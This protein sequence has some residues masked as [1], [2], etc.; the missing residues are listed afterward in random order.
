MLSVW[1]DKLLEHKQ[2]L[3]HESIAMSSAAKK[4]KFFMMGLTHPVSQLMELNHVLLMHQVG[5][6]PTID[7]YS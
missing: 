2:T 7:R 4:K 5:S 3:P 6:R 1:T